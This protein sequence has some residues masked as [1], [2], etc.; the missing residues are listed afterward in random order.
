MANKTITGV[1]FV[2]NPN[3]VEYQ[4]FPEEYFSGCDITIYFGDVFISE[5][6][7]IEFTLQEKVN[8]IYGYAS[9]TF[10]AVARGSRIVT[11]SFKIPFR[12]AGYIEAALSHIANADNGSA[13]EIAYKMGGSTGPDWIADTKESIDQYLDTKSIGY[14]DEIVNDG[15]PFFDDHNPIVPGDKGDF[16]TELRRVMQKAADNH[17]ETYG[18]DP[19]DRSTA[20]NEV[21]KWM[22]DHYQ[23]G[24]PTSSEAMAAC[25]LYT[26]DVQQKGSEGEYGDDAHSI[27]KGTFNLQHR[28]SQMVNG[29]ATSSSASS[30]ANISGKKA[31]LND[32]KFGTI[33]SYVA[34]QIC[35]A[36]KVNGGQTGSDMKAE[37]GSNSGVAPTKPPEYIAELASVHTTDDDLLRYSADMFKTAVA[38]KRKYGTLEEG[39]SIRERGTLTKTDL[40]NLYKDAGEEYD[41][42]HT[43]KV[44]KVK[45][46]QGAETR[47]SKYEKEV[48]GRAWSQD[49]DHK[50]QTFFYTDRERA[51]GT[52]VQEKLK[53]K[54]FDVYITYGPSPESIENNSWKLPDIFSFNTTVKAIRCMQLTSTGQTIMVNGQPIEEM[55]TFLAKDLD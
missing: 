55:Y 31:A 52:N 44:K 35:E 48:W 9:R 27:K 45:P 13:P 8:P 36:F 19:F 25:K 42:H 39:V 18:K 28:M 10:D 51:D 43:V 20:S 38:V 32:G 11:G 47:Y 54:G 33:T 12:E 26:A 49:I 46:A 17:P 6:S 14:D 53:Q 41:R 7:G 2:N 1:D 22:L 50:Y 5:I 23:V 4:L 40:S 37:M 16:I 21:L 29:T 34:Q 15:N 3:T 30:Q 24:D